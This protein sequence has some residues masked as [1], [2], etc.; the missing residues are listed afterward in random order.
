MSDIV[1]YVEGFFDSI[2]LMRGTYAPAKRAAFCALLATGIVCYIQPKG[3]FI[4]GNP[5][6]WDVITRNPKDSSVP[7]TTI[8]WFF[9]PLTAAVVGGVLI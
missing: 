5:R 1:N 2:G 8:P 7:P 6:P 3:M 4:G 9:A